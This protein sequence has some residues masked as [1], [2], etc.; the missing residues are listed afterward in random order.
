MADHEKITDPAEIAAY[1]ASVRELYALDQDVNAIEISD[2]PVVIRTATGAKVM[3]WLPI[4][5][6]DRWA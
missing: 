1:V 6:E 3:A 4:D 2:P 5:D